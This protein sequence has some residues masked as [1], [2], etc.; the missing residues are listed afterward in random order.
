VILLR[1]TKSACSYVISHLLYHLQGRF[2]Y[3]YLKNKCS[4]LLWSLAESPGDLTKDD[5]ANDL[6]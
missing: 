4:L 5:I 2:S 6:E 3:F 1:N